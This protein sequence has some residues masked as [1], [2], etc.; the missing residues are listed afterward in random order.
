MTD[1]LA[2][3]GEGNP[4]QGTEQWR[5]DRLGIPT[6]SMFS[7]V[8]AKRKRGGGPLMSR[9]KYAYKLVAER[10][11]GDPGPSIDTEAM[12]RGRRLEPIVANHYISAFM[13]DP[14]LVEVG[15]IKSQCGTYGCSPDGLVGESGLV[16]IKTA[17]PHIFIFDIAESGTGVP[18]RFYWQMVG[19]CL[20]TGRKWCD[21]AYFC[22]PISTLHVS[23]IFPTDDV[24]SE[25]HKT[26]GV[27]NSEV[28]EIESKVK[29]LLAA[30]SVVAPSADAAQRPLR[31]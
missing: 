2:A 21:L 13:A 4:H 1:V 8:M 15:F 27:F 20:V 9:V 3:L 17:D 22:E 19:Q 29:S 7:D 11:S 24:L 25:L 28:D 12:A 31:P 30:M 6:A 5:I 14:G 10:L 23:R 18:E 16:E 26:L